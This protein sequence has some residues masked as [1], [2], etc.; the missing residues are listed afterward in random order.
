VNQSIKSMIKIEKEESRTQ[1]F[2]S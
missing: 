1:R 2:L